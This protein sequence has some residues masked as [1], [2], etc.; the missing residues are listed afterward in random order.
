[1]VEL[2]T[3]T[4]PDTSGGAKVNAWD[5]VIIVTV[6][7]FT[8][9]VAV[10]ASIQAGE[11]HL[12]KY[13]PCIKR[14]KR[15]NDQVLESP[16]DGYLASEPTPGKKLPAG[17]E[18]GSAISS[19]RPSASLIAR[20]GPEH[21][22]NEV[23]N[24]FLA[25]RGM[26]WYFVGGA[27]FASNIGAEHF[28]GMAGDGARRGIAVAMYEWY[29]AILILCLGWI[30]SPIYRR[31][32]VYTTPEYLEY[33]FGAPCRH[34]L[35][36]ITIIMYVLTKMSAS[37]YGG[38]IV[39]QATLGWNLY[40]GA[41]VC[42]T[43]SAMYSIAGGLRAVM[44]T[45]LFQ[46]C[47]FTL[48]GLV[49]FAYSVNQIGGFEG[50]RENL[51]NQDRSGW[52]HLWKPTDDP[53]Y[54]WTGMIF[55]QP[56]GS[57]WY[58]CMDQ[59]LV[60]R[61]LSA[62][63]T[64]NAKAGC[65]FASMLKV[66]PPFLIVIPGIIASIYFDFSK[67]ED[68]TDAAYPTLLTEMMPHGIIG[69]MIS[70]IIT[71]MMSS[72]AS[73]FAAGSSVVTN[74][75]Y[76]KFRPDASHKQL[77][78]VG[79]MSILIFAVLSFCWIPIMRNGTGLYEQIVEIQSYLTPPIGIVLV[80]GVAWKP[81]NVYGAF[82][83]MI[84]GGLL[85][86][87]RLIFVTIKDDSMDG[88]LPGIW[89]TFFYMNFQHFALLLWVT[90]GVVCVVVSLL[91]QNKSRPSDEIRKYMIHWDK[92]LKLDATELTKPMWVNALVA[93]SA[94]AALAVTFSMWIYF[95]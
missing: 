31:C 64:A 92:V 55:G 24:F 53:D 40:L 66:L 1:M 59:D 88:D 49:V 8:M 79:R 14:S 26:Q 87:S 46:M 65:S 2:Y 54:P 23:S 20:D 25:D 29:A 51:D 43:L 90:A 32:G 39:F 52:F 15:N 83:A 56:L 17:D 11:S 71:A 42:I 76:L 18:R 68:G 50:I 10:I 89:N 74:D 78:W 67:I 69:L 81:A 13:F 82:S 91:T 7:F 37:I 6:L 93:G 12:A 41:G 35:S 4:V 84:V 85:G 95:A 34:Y 45:D 33:R 72:L 16:G 30:F 94:I 86:F 21:Q 27:L 44:Y 75:I 47:V 3:Q 73:V 5:V 36:L 9:V 19:Q 58:W 80:L 28:I 22:M 57:I 60:Q 61:V 48:G 62:K 70:S 38:A 77:V 63:D